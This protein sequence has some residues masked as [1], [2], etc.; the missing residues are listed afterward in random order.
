VP[1]Y[2]VMAPVE[3]DPPDLFDKVWK[4]DL[5]HQVISIGWSKIG[6]VSKMTREELLEAVAKEYPEKPPHTRALIR[7]MIWAFVHEIAPGDFVIARR[8]LKR[9]VAVGKAIEPAMDSPGRSPVHNH[10]RFLGVE[11]L[12]EPRD[13][14]FSTNVFQRYTLAEVS[15]VQFENYVHG[16]TAS[17]VSPPKTTEVE[18][19][20]EFVLEKYLEDFIVSNF[21][22]IFKGSLQMYKDEDGDGQQYPTDVG[23]ID[24]LATEPK[25]K[26]FVVIELK[27]GRP[28]DQVVGQV[29]RYMGW[30]KEKLCANGQ[31]VKGLIICRES[32]TKLSYALA[33]T[34][35]VDIRYYTVSF[36][37]TEQPGKKP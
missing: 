1:R 6:D 30:I 15:S 33:M 35:N 19:R 32:D 28:A 24:I 36:K 4:F 25:T 10:R 21:A 18:D 27:K 29:L 5:Q 17:A 22:A 12:P 11:W 26:S 2:W 31:A 23:P 37:L 13:R 34:Q 3:S 9:L 8:G 7:N 14:E 20:N 16:T